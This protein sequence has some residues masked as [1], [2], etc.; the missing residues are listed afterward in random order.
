MLH[1]IALLNFLRPNKFG[2]R[3]KSFFFGHITL[4]ATLGLVG[5]VEILKCIKV[6]ARHDFFFELIGQ[7][8]LLV[9][10][11]QD[12]LFAILE[13]AVKFQLV[14]NTSDIF[15][16]EPAGSFLSITCQKGDGSAI[17]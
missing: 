17:I 13:R 4:G 1:G 6:G 7:F 11:F 16:V 3:L 14:T 5:Q 12:C 10:S 2:Q 8:I 15:F 9:Y